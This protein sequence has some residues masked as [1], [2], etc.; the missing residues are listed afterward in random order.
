MNYRTAL[1]TG[2]ASGIG[3]ELALQLAKADVAIAALDVNASGLQS[4]ADQLSKQ[5]R[6]CAWSVADVTQAHALKAQVAAV[7]GQLGPIDLLIACAGLG[8]ETSALDYRADNMNAVLNV[9]LLGVSNSIAAVLPGMLQRRRGH[10]VAL[11]SLASYLGMP[12]MLGYCASKS[13][14]NAIMEGVRGEVKPLGV[15]VTTVCP[16]WIRTPMTDQLAD[17]VPMMDVE[18][19]ARRILQAIHKKKTFV[20]FPPLL[21]WR[22]RLLKWSPLF[23]RD[24]LLRRYQKVNLSGH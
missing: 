17:K 14:V 10:L 19:A 16:G 8:L 11:S 23:M 21:V 6:R 5:E 2:A 7:E 4:L 1:I 20:A 9:N 18:P 12:R 22:M 3:R 24:W 13:G 15:H